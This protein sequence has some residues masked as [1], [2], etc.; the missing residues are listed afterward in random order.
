VVSLRRGPV[1]S[2]DSS[3]IPPLPKWVKVP[4]NRAQ[5]RRGSWRQFP[6]APELGW[7][8]SLPS[9]SDERF[10][11]LVA[12]HNWLISNRQTPA[13]P[14][15][16]R[17][18]ELFGDEKHLGN[19]AR[20]Q[21][22]APGRLTLDLL[23][24]HRLPPPLPAIPVGT[25]PDILVVENSDPYWAAAD[26]LGEMKDHPIR[27]VAWGSGTAFPAQVE[28]LGVD[29][30]GDGPVSGV[31]WYWGDFD[32]RGIRIGADA[33]SANAAHDGVQV[34]PAIGL[35]EAM[36]SCNPQ[37]EGTISWQ[38]D[39]AAAAWLGP[40]LWATLEPIRRAKA[41]VA[42]EAVPRRA[43]ESWARSL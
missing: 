12:I 2:W 35:W 5:R 32:P 10:N 43:I 28:T 6:W 39:P 30:A 29:I 4:A 13:V 15:R 27:A 8:A 20:T 26:V 25:G 21:L 9:L 36:A 19:L 38:T 14:V 11:D 34:L 37:M 23:R 41:R 42:Q 18:V 7:V 40:H 22:F 33:A 3:T 17:S 24:C 31:A 16:Y 1:G